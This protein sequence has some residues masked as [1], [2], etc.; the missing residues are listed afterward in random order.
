VR[1]VFKYSLD[2]RTCD[3]V[4]PVGAEVVAAEAIDG[5]IYVWAVVDPDARIESRRFYVLATGEVL[6]DEQLKH[7]GTVV[8]V[9]SHVYHVF[10]RVPSSR[11][12]T[13]INMASGVVGGSLIQAG[14]IEGGIRQ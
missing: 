8:T 14:N 10:E 5:S 4:M 9:N 12:T 3:V 13:H 7:V 2:T 11:S 6:P 1:K